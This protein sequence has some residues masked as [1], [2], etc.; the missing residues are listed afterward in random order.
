MD[1]TNIM[2]HKTNYL[3]MEEIEKMLQFCK[4]QLRVRDYMLI[5]ILSRT[6]RRVSEI[7]GTKPFIYNVGLRPKD[8]HPDGLIEFTVLKKNPIRNFDGRF[9]KISDTDL[10]KKRLNKKPVRN[11]FG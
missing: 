7:V 4:D 6:G 1:I 3:S 9:R 2:K 10:V 8:L 11:L 5:M